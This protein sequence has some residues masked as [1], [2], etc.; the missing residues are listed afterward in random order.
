MKKIYLLILVLTC[1]FTAFSQTDNDGDGFDSSVDCDDNNPAISTTAIAGTFTL[2]DNQPC[3]NEQFTLSLTG[4]TGAIEWMYSTNGG[5]SWMNLGSGNDAFTT[6]VPNSGQAAIV[7][8]FVYHNT[9]LADTSNIDTIQIFDNQTWYEDLDLDNFG[10]SSNSLSDCH[11]PNGYILNSSDCNDNDATIHPGAT[12]IVNNGI[13]ENC[14]GSDITSVVDN[15][16]DGVDNTID[17]DDNNNLVTTSAV[18][19]TFSIST[20]STICAGGTFDVSLNGYTATTINW[21]AS[22][23]NGASWNPTGDT[24]ANFTVNANDPINV[25]VAA[26]VNYPNCLQ[27]TSNMINIIILANQ[28]WY[29]D[30]DG[31]TYGDLNNPTTTCIQPV[32]HVSDASDC[33]DTNGAINPAATDIP[34]NS[35][36]EDC[37]GSDETAI[38]DNDG[39]GFDNTVDCNDNNASINSGAGEVCDGIDNNCDGN[40]DEG[41]A[42]TTYYVDAD[43]D[44]FGAGTGADYCSNPGIGYSTDNTD[45]D[46]NNPTIY[47]GAS[48]IA[49]NGTDEDCDGSDYITIFD[50][51]GDGYLSNIDCDDSNSSIYPGAG[52]IP[53]NG[54]DEDCD[55]SDYN[56]TYDYDGDG[57]DSNI[58]CDDNNSSVYPGASEICDGI[59]NNCD[60]SIDE[61][62]MVVYYVDG[63]LDGFGGG[64]AGEFCNDPGTGFTQDFSDCDDSNAAIHPAMSE[65]CDNLDNN[66]NGNIDEGLSLSTYYLDADNDNFGAGIGSD[67]CSDPGL[68]YSTSDADCNDTIA[69]I[70]PSATEIMDN[71]IDEDCN[72]TDLLSGLGE[73][74]IDVLKIYPN[75]GNDVLTIN[76]QTNVKE[77]SIKLV[78]A[79]G[80]VLLTKTIVNTNNSVIQTNDLSSGVYYIEIMLD[81]KTKTYSW[82]KR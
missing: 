61:G 31:D 5:Q 6:S 70:N 17:C 20:A 53:N 58:D 2:S 82:I 11:Q 63:D 32:N 35:I 76:F 4:Y 24:Q 9:C 60:G 12:E 48:E 43:N 52:E 51:D 19:G 59:D 41:L 22:F 69:T 45:C 78:S 38:F 40:I 28:T 49:D 21:M 68:G 18:A 44:N 72:G 64:W 16:G 54:I 7:A 29:A 71:G 34:N 10:N 26:F 80:K 81:G 65:V 13:D 25:L 75:P 8:A 3:V 57:S 39:D 66:C 27:D 1:Y 74:S 33:D 62:L 50:N 37:T 30:T 36:D 77:V 79:I 42:I 47:P 15:D 23:D 73:N 56:S 46:D 55:G 67:F 14:D